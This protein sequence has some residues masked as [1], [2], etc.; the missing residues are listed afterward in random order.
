MQ[1]NQN[2]GFLQGVGVFL[3]LNFMAL[4]TAAM[5][6]MLLVGAETFFDMPIYLKVVDMACFGVLTFNAIRNNN[7]AILKGVG[8]LFFACAVSGLLYG[9]LLAQEAANLVDVNAPGS[10]HIHLPDEMTVLATIQW[11]MTF[12][13]ILFAIATC[14]SSGTSQNQ[15]IS[16][17]AKNKNDV[18][19]NSCDSNPEIP[20]QH[21]EIEVSWEQRFARQNA[22][23]ARLESER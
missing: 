23:R 6:A 7:M 2:N 5:A 17:C 21:I 11:V 9:H 19:G 15:S 12:C 14:G 18:A 16:L 4:L 1:A 22:E 13:L 20:V 10:F 3:G 8:I